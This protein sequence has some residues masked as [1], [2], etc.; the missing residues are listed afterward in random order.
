MQCIA[1]AEQKLL[2]ESVQQFVQKQYVGNFR[3]SSIDDCRESFRLN[4]PDYARLG[5]LA[6]G[7]PESAGGF[8]GSAFE[9]AIIA[10]EL[11]RGLAP[12]P[13]VTAAVYTAQ[14][15]LGLSDWTKGKVLLAKMVSGESLLVLAHE[16]AQAR[17][18]ATFIGTKARSNSRGGYTLTGSKTAVIGGVNADFF[19]VTARLES[20]NGNDECLGLFLIPSCQLELQCQH[21]MTFDGRAVSSLIF[22]E[23]RLES[24]ALVCRSAMITAAIQRA[25]DHALIAYSAEALG[26]MQASLDMTRD[27]LLTREQYGEAL[28]EF[29]VLRHRLA[30][31]FIASEKARSMV[32]TGIHATRESDEE[33][34]TKIASATKALVSQSGEFVTALG[35]QLHG[36]IGMADECSVGHYYKR[37][38]VYEL[39]LGSATYHLNNFRELS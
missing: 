12:E 25:T 39:L 14:F 33:H 5:W 2:R 10:E 37:L 15:I 31:M 23:L 11:G 20:G 29:Q 24:D 16:E 18:D 6:A 9:T 1:T 32:L 21:T 19:L 34:R 4:W 27:Y 35:I 36:G 3:R 8:G 38:N 30:D 17:G 7:L 13:F 28:S 22:N 26:A